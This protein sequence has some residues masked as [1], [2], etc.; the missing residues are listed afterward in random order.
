MPRV[1]ARASVLMSVQS[2]S[3]GSLRSEGWW[4]MSPEQT[5]EGPRLTFGVLGSLVVHRNGTPLALGGR[6]Q[7]AVLAFLLCDAGH[8]VS[9]GRIADALWGEQPPASFQ[10]TVQTYVF[11][12]RAMLEPDRPR[13][14]AGHV[15][16]TE[17]GGN[18]R[19]DLSDYP[20]DA[21]TFD[22]LVQGGRLALEA[23]QPGDALPL[24]DQALALWRGD[25]L[26]DLADFEFVAPVAARLDELR[27]ST[28]EARIEAE[29]ALGHHQA[30]AAELDRLVADH[31]L[32]EELH[33]QR[34]VALY[35]SGRQSDALAAFRE[36]RAKLRDELGVEPSPP[37]QELNTRVL[38]HD[39]GLRW[40]SANGDPTADNGQSETTAPAAGSARPARTPAVGSLLERF[41]RPWSRR[42]VAMGAALVVVAATGTTAAVIARHRSPPRAT[43][44]ANSVGAVRPDGSV[45]AAVPVGTNPVAVAYG[46]RA[47]WV[48]NRTDGTVSR[49]DPDNR[50]VVQTIDAGSIPEALT[51]TRDDVWVADFAESSVTRIN[52]KANK[53]VDTL[54]VGSEPSAIASGPGGVW[55]AN[56]GDN[57]IQRIDPATGKVDEAIGV[58]AH[59]DGIAV[60]GDTVWV[61]NGGDGTVSR[62][63]ARTKAVEVIPVGS[64]P[65]GIAVSGGDVWVADHLEQSVTRI[66]K[67]TERTQHISVGD[68][69]DSVV[70]ADGVIWVSEAY[71]GVLSRIDPA[72]N[73][74]QPIALGISPRGLAA[75]PSHVWVAGGA[76]TTAAHRGG[77]LT[78]AHP[79]TIVIDPSDAYSAWD[80]TLH[81]LM[82]DGLV[83]FR[84]G[85]GSDW[86]VLVPDLAMRIPRPS[87]GGRTYTFT[88][89]PGIKYSTGRVVQASDFVEAVRRALTNPY[90]NPGY[91]AGIIGGQQCID[92][93]KPCD[94]SR[95][96]VTDNAA[97]RVTFH[98]ATPDP[99]FLYKLRYFIVPIPAGS[100]ADPKVTPV[101]GT[102]PYRIS[103]YEPGKAVVL[104]RNPFFHQWSFA[105]QPD[106]YPNVIRWLTMD[107]GAASAV[108]RG[109][110]DVASLN[111][112]E[113]ERESILKGLRA[114][115]PTQVK[116]DQ[117]LYVS[118]FSLDTTV[119]PFNHVEARRALSYAFDRAKMIDEVLGASFAVPT[120]QLLP[121]NFAGYSWHCPYTTEPN[122]GHYHGADLATARRLVQSS[123]TKGETVTVH[124][125]AFGKPLPIQNYLV[126]V[127]NDIGYHARLH[128]HRDNESFTQRDHLQVTSNVWGADFPLASNYFVPVVTCSADYNLG[129]YCN[130]ALDRDAAR[131][132]ALEADDP[133][134]AVRAWTAIDRT[135]TDDAPVVPY[136]NLVVWTLTSQRVGN[137]QSSPHWG[138]LLSQMWVQ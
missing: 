25:V 87:D 105:A 69:P 96:V 120:C 37:L 15:V 94:L 112:S 67:N 109:E 47:L 119:P 27:L 39:P 35:R 22:D 48:A 74:R 72:T 56:K 52:I 71:T 51:V 127:L 42:A 103:E 54:K 34:I 49:V 130:R 8:A 129:A 57:T 12:L 9:V 89:R 77:T 79:R 84:Y 132:T 50:S 26:A 118:Y 30:A 82:Y 29:L 20:L 90:G 86:Q 43:L 113:P 131:A 66:D 117:T 10:A 133:G 81:K 61:A 121:P 16:V 21:S 97:R 24:F 38:A 7:R 45:A 111:N 11:H 123:G 4:P 108:T 14:S 28:L 19:L 64:G 75:T 101:P 80:V 134:A 91:Y 62:I 65:K 85:S 115:Y 124:D 1:Q 36:L 59:P 32:R 100:T 17:P 5:G 88:L 2:V 137:Y 78:V 23:G 3:S 106:G 73:A 46:Q 58:G 95:G 63:S 107:N 13:G 33:R 6:Q 70:A 40:A 122:D 138:W 125:Y 135:V 44:V 18:Y 41:R 128:Q 55:V 60:D 126:K 98:L 68:G 104:T 116:R 136:D 31:P 83:T 92:H 110:V 93:P 76:F 102:G 114:R 99:E 53:A